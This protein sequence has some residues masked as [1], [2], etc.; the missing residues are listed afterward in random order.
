V[1]TDREDLLREAVALVRRMELLV[2]PGNRVIVVGFRSTGWMSVYFNADLMY[3]FDDL[4][5]LRRAYI[6]GLLYRSGGRVLAELHRQRSESETT[7]VRRDLDSGPLVEFRDRTHERVRWL[8]DVLR[9]GGV[10]ISRQIPA[11]DSSLI[12]DVIEFLGVVL[13]SAEFLAPAIKR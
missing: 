9:Q 6:D 5:R 10:T 4:G 13:D 8:R 3:Q 11:D 7:L 12:H 2:M 1:E